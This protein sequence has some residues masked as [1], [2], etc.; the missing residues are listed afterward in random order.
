LLAYWYNTAVYLNTQVENQ[1]INEKDLDQLIELLRAKHQARHPAPSRAPIKELKQRTQLSPN[2][3]APR[4]NDVIATHGLEPTTR[5]LEAWAAR[6]SGCPII[7]IAHAMG[8]SIEHAKRLIREAHTAI[9]EDLKEN[10]NLNRE[11]DL[12]RVDGLLSSYYPRARAGDVESANVVLRA[13]RHRAQLVGLEAP[14]DPGRSHP[15]NV[16]IW[17]QNQLPSIN[18]LVDSLP[19]ELPP[20]AP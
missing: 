6:V 20:S 7:D 10:L 9:A 16:M 12:A 1:N 17:I 15:E 11:L 14:P 13:M 2:A 18:R 4:I 5:A 8:V 3:P 19:L